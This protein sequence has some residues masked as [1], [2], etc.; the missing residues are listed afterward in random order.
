MWRDFNSREIARTR[1]LPSKTTSSTSTFIRI[2]RKSKRSRVTPINY[3]EESEI[4]DN[5]PAP[6][7]KKIDIRSIRR[8]LG[9]DRNFGRY[10]PSMEAR[11]SK[12]WDAF[13]DIEIQSMVNTM[14]IAMK[15]IANVI[16]GKDPQVLIN[17]MVNSKSKIDSVHCSIMK[18]L[19]MALPNRSTQR[20]ALL[21]VLC[22]T[23]PQ[24]DLIDIQIGRK[25]YATA[26]INYNILQSGRNILP[27][28]ATLPTLQFSVC[29]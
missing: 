26:R 11:Q 21:A 23:L 17:S 12:D 1:G 29:T 18:E 27:P 5:T 7:K 22:E 9:L 4:E 14:S 20:A 10:L 15:Q 13:N 2:I 24:K 19:I 28:K 25:S 16:Y 3:A 6:E 8:G